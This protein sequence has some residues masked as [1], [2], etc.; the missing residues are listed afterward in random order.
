[1]KNLKKISRKDLKNIAGGAVPR[2]CCGWDACGNC[3]YWVYNGTPCPK[4]IIPDC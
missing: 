1:M 2:Q 4:I 3:V